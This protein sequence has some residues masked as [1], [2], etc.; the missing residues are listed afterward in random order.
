[1]VVKSVFE[2]VIIL[3]IVLGDIMVMRGSRGDMGSET[4]S[5]GKSRSIG[6]YRN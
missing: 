4:P 2:T 1:M 6:F 3:T 5:P